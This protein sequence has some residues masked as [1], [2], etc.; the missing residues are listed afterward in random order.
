MNQSSGSDNLSCVE[1]GCS[2]A[3]LVDYLFEL[4]GYLIIKGAVGAEDIAEMNAWADA[5][6]HYMDLSLIHI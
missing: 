2:D 1:A 6:W 3:Y 5:H 4:N